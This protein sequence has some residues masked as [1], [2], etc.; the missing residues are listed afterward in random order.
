MS[1]ASQRE[2]SMSVRRREFLLRL[3]TLLIVTASMMPSSARA[4]AA[5]IP[6]F[7]GIWAH[8]YLT[9]FEPPA[10]GP[11]PVLNRSRR[12]DGVANFDRL[13]GDHTNPVLQPWAA[14]VVKKHGEMSIA[15]ITYGNPSNQCWPMPM[16]FIYKQFLVEIIQTPDT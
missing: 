14:E 4:Q 15:G 13:V 9:G 16:P 3:A 10:S 8:P 11:G 6:D 2:A 7:S 1:A 12:P 5:L